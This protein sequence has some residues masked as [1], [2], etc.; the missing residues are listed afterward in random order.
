M[1][2]WLGANPK[3]HEAPHA[4]VTLTRLRGSMSP[5]GGKIVDRALITYKRTREI[6]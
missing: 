3:H 2:E 1:T 5:Q 6:R 4:Y